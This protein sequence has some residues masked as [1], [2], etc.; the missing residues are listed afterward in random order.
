[1]ALY[2]IDKGKVSLIQPVEFHGEAELQK[3][4]DKN[5]EDI[6]GVRLIES[7]YPI[8]N[9]RLD[10]LGIDEQNVP[11]VIEYKWKSDPGVIIQGLF[12]L[13]WV[14]MKE[15][16]KAFELLVKDKLGPT[17]I[18][19]SSEPR[20]IVIA[21][22]FD[23]REL[24]AID[25]I[26][27]SVELKK[28]SY[29]ENLINIE[30]VTPPKTIRSFKSDSEEAGQIEETRT[31][32]GIIDKASPEL[33]KVFYALRD[34]ILNLGGD[35]RE[36]VGAWYIDYRKSSTFV[37]VTPQPKNNCLLIY[38]KMGD[39][40]VTDPQGWTSPLPKNWSYGKLNTKFEI[41]KSDQLDYAMELIKQAY[42]Y[43]P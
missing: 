19:W 14:R 39:K 30:D 8:P 24:S 21:K 9:G 1:M 15:N 26:Q 41:H 34:K 7:E 13:K 4:I 17:E 32:E 38:I 11:V 23:I 33:T 43:V 18:N 25:M 31:V 35:V 42:K 6:T 2:Q 5:L 37:T 29:Y 40:I 36:V 20:L 10:A 28:Y 12:Y 16:R 22:E 27:A 3:L